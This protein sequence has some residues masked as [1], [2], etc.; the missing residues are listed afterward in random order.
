[1]LNWQ[2]FS[3]REDI[4]LLPL[5]EQKKRF[6]WEQQRL[7]EQNWFL[8][9]QIVAGNSN[10]ASSGGI[11]ADGPLNGAT[12]TAR[13]TSVTT[14]A[15]GEFTFPFILTE[16]DEITITGGTDSITG[17]PY[18]GE[19]KGYITDTVKVICPVTTLAFYDT[20]AAS[21]DEALD[22]VIDI[23]TDYGFAGIT[24]DSLNGDYIKKTIEDNDDSSVAMQ[25]FTTFVDSLA[26]AGAV[27]T[28]NLESTSYTTPST[29]KQAK[30]N[31][32]KYFGSTG[33][34]GIRSF[35]TTEV[36]EPKELITNLATSLE[37]TIESSLLDDLTGICTDSLAD[38]NYKTTRIQG[39]NRIIKNTIKTQVNSAVVGDNANLFTITTTD[40]INT[41]LSTETSELS[42]IE[43]SRDNITTRIDDSTKTSRLILLTDYLQSSIRLFD[44]RGTQL[45]NNTLQNLYAFTSVLELGTKLYAYSSE[46]SK[47]H[48]L[49]DATALLDAR[50]SLAWTLINST[51]STLPLNGY[52]LVLGADG[53]EYKIN[54][55]GVVE[56]IALPK[57]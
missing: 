34:I 6:A 56:S 57:P 7:A 17:M 10:G 36:I 3:K 39:I 12:V 47:Y 29:N 49:D 25:S 21:Y 22:N 54:Y 46:G 52:G 2:T 42:K 23:A 26:E 11:G 9:Q 31:L 13:G 37:S 33:N 53:T 55:Y 45:A 48:T 24:K 35:V 30:I 15:L 1:M 50:T 41:A 43:T 18:E 19:L 20:E 51:N 8:G 28:R 5:S 40:A 14:N 38:S 4:K 16:S 32:Y 44:D 27:L